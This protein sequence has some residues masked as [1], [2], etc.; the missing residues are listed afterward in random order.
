MPKIFGCIMFSARS[1]YNNFQDIRFNENEILKL[2]NNDFSPIQKRMEM[3]NELACYK[4]C[5]LLGI[6]LMDHLQ[7][8]TQ[9]FFNHQQLD[10]LVIIEC[11][12]LQC[13]SCFHSNTMEDGPSYF[14]LLQKLIMKV[15]DLSLSLSDKIS[16]MEK[17]LGCSI[18]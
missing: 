13:Y 5:K 7:I 4:E 2:N 14:L 17:Q 11:I 9:D 12:I 16:L 1:D 15:S 10:L 18:F 6:F 8:E 3:L